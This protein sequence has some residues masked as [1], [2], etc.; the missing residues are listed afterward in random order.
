MYPGS[1]CSSK[2]GP[3]NHSKIT[4]KSLTNMAKLK[5]IWNKYVKLEKEKL[6]QKHA[7]LNN[8]LKNKH[9]KLPWNLEQNRQIQHVFV[10]LF[11]RSKVASK[12]SLASYFIG[13]LG[14]DT[15]R[16]GDLSSSTNVGVN[17]MGNVGPKVGNYYQSVPRFDWKAL[18]GNLTRT[19]CHVFPSKE[20][21]LP[22]RLTAG[23]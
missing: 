2:T 7:K 8:H 4:W 14:R 18:G 9:A 23:T 16:L 12:D 10:R 21:L 20:I 3:G 19:I 1:V 15:V 22:W 17:L 13:F 11:D 6:Q 5:V